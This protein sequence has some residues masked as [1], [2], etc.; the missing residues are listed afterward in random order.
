[1]E[2]YIAQDG[3]IP[4]DQP[5]LDTLGQP[6]P[7][8]QPQ[9]PIYAG[10]LMRAKAID[11]AAAPHPLPAHLTHIAATDTPTDPLFYNPYTPP[12]PLVEEEEEE[13]YPP[14]PPPPTL[15]AETTPPC[16]AG[17]PSSDQQYLL[18]QHQQQTGNLSA[19]D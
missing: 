14:P 4:T 8:Q 1:M 17:G 10:D 18:Q 9:Q 19:G 16:Y 12:P 13:G 6:Q 7:P 11:P 5:Q 15:S 3:P 2:G